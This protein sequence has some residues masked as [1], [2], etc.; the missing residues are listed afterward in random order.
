MLQNTQGGL[1]GFE[2][3]SPQ[4][5]L[6]TYFKGNEE[7]EPTLSFIIDETQRIPADALALEIG[8]GPTV[9]YWMC[10]TPYLSGIYLADFLDVNLAE[11]RKW[12]LQQPGRFDWADYTRMVLRYEGQPAASAHQ[13]VQ[14]EQ[15]ARQQVQGYLHCDITS[16]DPLG[17]QH[18]Q[19]YDLVASFYCADSITTSKTAWFSYMKNIFSLLRPGGFFIGG[20]L[21]ACSSYPVG[22]LQFPSAQ[23]D[24]H[25]FRAVMQECGFEMASTRVEVAAEGLPTEPEERARAQNE[26]NYDALVLA[27]G[28]IKQ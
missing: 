13:L 24:E 27:S 8:C 17:A 15:L 6:N 16:P 25:D 5:Y 4:A 23:V 28:F 20:A 22:S 19:K 11:Q 12:V 21:R 10:L 9:C 1:A 7:H 26:Y 2:H 3:W 18:R 14:R